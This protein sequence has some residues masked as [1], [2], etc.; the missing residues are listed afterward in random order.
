MKRRFE[1]G[2]ATATDLLAAEARAAQARSRAIDAV[3]GQRLAEARLR[4]VTTQHT[5]E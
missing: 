5:S 1:E 3:T 2:L 4:F